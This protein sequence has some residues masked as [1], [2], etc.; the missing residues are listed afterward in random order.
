MAEFNVMNIPTGVD[1]PGAE[2]V[3]RVRDTNISPDTTIVV[4]CAG[5]TRSIIGAQSLINAG[6]SNK[7]VALRNGTMGWHLAGFKLEHGMVRPP[8][9]VSPTGH[10]KALAGAE[11]AA[12][13]FGVIK[14]K[15]E[16]L[17]QWRNEQKERTLCILDV[18]TEEEFKISHISDS[19]HA[20]GGQLV[21][22]TDVYVAT[23]KARVVL[24][25]DLLVRALMTAS[26]LMQLGWCEVYVLESGFE[27][28]AMSSGE[29]I[30]PC[31]GLEKQKITFISPREALTAQENGS[32]IICLDKSLSC[33]EKHPKGAWF[34]I[35]SKLAKDLQTNK[36][37]TPLIFISTDVKISVLAALDM[38]DFSSGVSVVEGGINAWETAG[39]VL[40]GGLNNLLS[41]P[42]DVYLRAYDREDPVEVEKAMNDYLNWELGLV[43]QI[44]RPGGTKFEIYPD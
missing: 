31:F 6:V 14:I 1:M 41:V 9:A 2:L 32:T 21:Q 13:R 16:T 37:N 15:Q 44:A 28:Q 30:A 43:E 8:P 39:L 33:R 3:H 24:V 26:W 25:D 38:R 5:R 42:N 7:V 36:I 4:N 12:K 34:S 40:E 17:D 20:P 22:A 29:R 10:Q 23:Q 35:R 18:R 11:A 27:G 19:R